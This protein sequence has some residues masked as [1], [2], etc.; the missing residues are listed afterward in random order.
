[1]R[2]EMNPV[3]PE[4]APWPVPPEPR[5]IQ[6]GTTCGCL[7]AIALIAA[8]VAPVFLQERSHRVSCMSNQKQVALA[9]LLY[10]QD[11][12]VRL[13][14][15]RNWMDR[16]YPYAKNWSIF[17]CTEVM[18]EH[19]GATGSTSDSYGI[20]MNGSISGHRTNKLKDRDRT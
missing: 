8:V 3:G 9:L 11:S 1:M 19:G 18:R 2:R 10:A 17:Q 7:C 13:A 15:A 4:T 20:A 14:P 16:V 5:R 12:D 6:L